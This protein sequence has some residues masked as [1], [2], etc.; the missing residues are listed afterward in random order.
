MSN[1]TFQLLVI[2]AGPGGY[3]AAIRAAQL[4]FKVACVD[5]MATLGGT[6]LNMGCIPSKSLLQCSETYEKTAH[7]IK[8]QGVLASDVSFDFPT[9]MKRKESIVKTLVDGIASHFKKHGITRL[10]GNAQFV[11]PNEVEVN[12]K[13]YQAQQILIA[14]GSEPIPLPFLPFDEKLVVSSTGALSLPTVPK[15]MAVIGGGIIGVEL[16]SVYRRLGSAVT[17]IEMLDMITPPMDIA[18]SKQ[19]LQNLRKQGIEFFL[20][21]QLTEAK[22]VKEGIALSIEKEQKKE[23]I[24]ADVVLVAIGR[25]PYTAGLNTEAAGIRL[26]KKGLIE[27]DSNFRTSQPH[28][29]AIG[30]VIDGPMLAHKASHEGIAVAEL[31]AGL[32]PSI[33]Y[34]SIPSVI[35]T[36]PEV[37]SVGLT[38]AEASAIGRPLLIGTSFFRGNARARCTGD[39]TGFVKVIGDEATGRLLGMHIIGAHASELIGEGLIALDKKATLS[40]LAHACH[41]HPTLSETIMEACQQALGFAIHG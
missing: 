24:E 14:T 36:D 10:E 33:N 37:A 6:C 40:D 1:E 23:V 8:E 31:L 25:R 3:V 18:L 9:I 28:I 20:G 41:A 17:V 12:G 19:L 16:A 2:G 13:R 21:T 4:G 29:Y 11:S 5:K 35:Y 22:A 30:D 39:L 26:T 34:I 32:K 7:S 27:V 15:R 38:E